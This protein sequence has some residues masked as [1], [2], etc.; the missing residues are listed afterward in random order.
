[1]AAIERPSRSLDQAGRGHRSDGKNS[2]NRR[3]NTIAFSGGCN[4][5]ISRPQSSRENGVERCAAGNV[6]AVI[7]EH[8]SRRAPA[9]VGRRQPPSRRLWLV[10]HNR[11]N[12]ARPNPWAKPS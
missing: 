12:F 8:Q 11:R 1:M 10:T 2:T 6:H 4:P 3:L 7:P 9:I 5:K